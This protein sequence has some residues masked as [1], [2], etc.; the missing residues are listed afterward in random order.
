MRTNERKSNLQVHSK[1]NQP[2]AIT[3]EFDDY[4]LKKSM[5]FKDME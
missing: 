2:I 1:V 3:T 4:Q 5:V